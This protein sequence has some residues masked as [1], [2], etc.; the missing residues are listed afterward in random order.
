MRAM[1]LRGAVRGRTFKTTRPDAAAL[2]PPDLVDRDFSA[3]RPHALWVADLTYVA[4]WRGFV[5]VAFVIDV[6]ARRIVGWRA[7]SALRTDRALDALEQAIW[8]RAET[9]GLVHHS[10]CGGQGGFQRSS[11]HRPGRGGDDYTEAAFGAGRTSQVA[12]A[13]PTLG[14]AA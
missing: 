4:T 12:L 8:S 6:V 5:Y 11:Q 13:R 7:S 1:G 3:S 10:D 9:N 14:W 2:R